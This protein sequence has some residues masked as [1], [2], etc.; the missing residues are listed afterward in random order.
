MQMTLIP[1]RRAVRLEMERHG[2]RLRV[3]GTDYD[4]S[5][6]AEGALLPRSAVTGDWL[7]GD[8]ERREGRLHLAL[9]LPHGETAPAETLFPTPITLTADGPVALPPYDLKDVQ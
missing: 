7:A 6:L 2:D 3:N 8:V 9:F 5:A 4:F 1:I